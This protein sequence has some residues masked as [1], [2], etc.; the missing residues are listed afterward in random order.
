MFVCYLVKSAP[1]R[2]S[3]PDALC[4]LRDSGAMFLEGCCSPSCL[5]AE[6]RDVLRSS[7]LRGP[8]R[9]F[10]N[11]QP[12]LPLP[13]IGRLDTN[14]TLCTPATLALP[15]RRGVVLRCVNPLPPPPP[16]PVN[17]RLCVGLSCGHHYTLNLAAALPVVT[18]LPV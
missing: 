16:P 15:G 4:Q 13:V 7:G 11:Y 3:A 8:T 6:K 10:Y 17:G 1:C 14:Y 12:V 9:H 18:S 5:A 2:E